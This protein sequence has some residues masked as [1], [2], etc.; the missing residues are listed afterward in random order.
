MKNYYLI[1]F[2]TLF[3]T[4]CFSQVTFQKGHFVNNNNEIVHCLIEN[5]EWRENPVQ[6]EYKINPESET[7]IA[8]IGM[9]K[10]FTIDNFRKYKRFNVEIDKSSFDPSKPDRNREPN[11]TEETLFLRSLLEGKASLYYFKE[12]QAERFFYQINDSNPE[13]LIYKR[14]LFEDDKVKYN[15]QFKKQLF[16]DLQC[17]EMSLEEFHKLNYETRSLL[18]IF[19][20]YNSCIESEYTVHFKRRKATWNGTVKAGLNLTN[21]GLKQEDH[22][23]NVEFTLDP[24]LRLGLELEVV[25]PILNNKWALFFEPTYSQLKAEREF[26]VYTNEPLP[27]NP[28]HYGSYNVTASVNNTALELPV[29]LRHYIFMTSTSRLF[30]N[31]GI[32]FHFLFNSSSIEAITYDGPPPP[33]LTVEQSWTPSYF[34]GGGYDFNSKFNLEARYYP[35]KPVSDN[36]FFK[37]NQDHTFAIIVGYRLFQYSQK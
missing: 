34:I 2:F 31:A 21:F 4:I 27:S 33:E 16:D 29:G 7:K 32:S 10:E 37:I 30:F 9:V 12:D 25:L 20:K 35:I 6:F 26:N 13:Q 18:K 19:Q 8:T 22:P 1:L 28:A 23:K 5:R 11:F 3:S 15:N 24:N 36:G 14:F 17:E